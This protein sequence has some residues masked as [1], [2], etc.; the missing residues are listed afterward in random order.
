[1]A[2]E[3]E[4]LSRAI[5]LRQQ[6]MDDLDRLNAIFDE[7]EG[8]LGGWD[9]EADISRMLLV[10]PQVLALKTEAERIMRRSE[11]KR[12]KG[13]SDV[14]TRF[15]KLYYI[16]TNLVHDLKRVVTIEKHRRARVAQEVTE[17]QGSKCIKCGKPAR[18]DNYCKRCARDE[19]I[20]VHGKIV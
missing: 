10:A 7:L 13:F 17:M 3:R 19:G 6:K 5:A 1:M 16:K 15:T 12:T 2:T 11:L 20:I 4:K 9:W 8:I 14:L 18:I